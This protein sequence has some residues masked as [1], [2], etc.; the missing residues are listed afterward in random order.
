MKPKKT[1]FKECHLAA[2]Q[3]NDADL[4][5]EELKVGV[6]VDLVRDVDNKYDP[7]AVAVVYHKTSGQGELDDFL[8]GY[9]PN[10]E[11]IEIAQFLDMGWSNLFECRISKIDAEEHYENQIRLAIR[12]NKN[13]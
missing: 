6:V 12:I 2:R 3:Y 10:G 11:N 7:N 8:I 4:M 9:L 1:L 13:N 5:W